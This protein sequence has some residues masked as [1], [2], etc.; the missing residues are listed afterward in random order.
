[1]SLIG[2]FLKTK[3]SGAA[4]GVEKAI[5]K[6]VVEAAIAGSLLVA[7]AEGGISDDE[8][9]ALETA[10]AA[11]E[12]FKPWE[13]EFG[14][15]ISKYASQIIKAP[16]LGKQFAMDEI[17]DL[18]AKNPH[19]NETVFNCILTVA[20]ASGKIEDEERAVLVEIAKVLNLDIKKF[21]I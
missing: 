14:K 19:D 20:D 4:E 16:R 2:K 13:A 5:T 3:L 12:Q 15:L 8:V 9:E 21:G 1:M 17:R 10:L 7:A 6:D 18:S 11:V